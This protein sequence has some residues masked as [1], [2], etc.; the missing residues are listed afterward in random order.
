M[1]E[2]YIATM[3]LHAVGDTIGFFNS[4]WEFN[5]HQKVFNLTTTNEILYDFINRGGINDINL[6]GWIVSDDTVLHMAVA[7]ALLKPFNN[8]SEFENILKKNLVASMRDMKNREPGK[9][10]QIYIRMI[11]DSDDISNIPYDNATGGNGA[12]MR[13]LCIGLAFCGKNNRSK[14]IEYAIESSRLTHMSAIGY[15]GGLTTALFTAFA[16]ENVPITDWPFELIDLVESDKVRKYINK[17]Y[18][19]DE[20]QDYEIFLSNWRKYIEARF[21]N[22]T[23]I[24]TKAQTNL[25]FRTKFHYENFVKDNEHGGTIGESGYGVGIMAYDSLVDSGPMWEKLIIYATLN[26]GDSDTVG[27]IATGWFGAMYGMQSIPKNNLKYLEYKSEL[28]NI[29]E[30]LYLKYNDKD[31]EK[32]KGLKKDFDN[33][34]SKYKKVKKSKN[35]KQNFDSDFDSD[36]D[37][38]SDSD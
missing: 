1:E 31:L 17:K 8:Y 30:Q 4:N 25:L 16:I 18:Y 34:K 24:T 20:L 36:F 6:E 28:T 35:L 11:E 7:N 33:N 21:R 12:A 38:D 23:L 3:V 19:D 10:T 9:T 29:G 37:F 14:L 22:R 2:R 15:L 27:C 5:Y 13:N 26:I 32:D